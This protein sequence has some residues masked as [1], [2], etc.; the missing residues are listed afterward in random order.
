MDIGG[1]R[2]QFMGGLKKF[3]SSLPECPSGEIASAEGGKLRLP[4]ARSPL[5]IG[6]L[7]E[8]RM[9][10]SGVWGRAPE[11][12]AILNNFLA[13]WS[14]FWALVNLVFC[15]CIFVLLHKSTG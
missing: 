14:T 15:V 11:T 4:K 1:V 2:F 9:L 6:G 10:P 7:G 13:K 12:D 3:L 8:R 5:R